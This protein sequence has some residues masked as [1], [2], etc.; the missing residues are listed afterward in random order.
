MIIQWLHDYRNWL[1][2]LPYQGI[3]FF[4]LL[5]LVGLSISLTQLF[6]RI[7][8]RCSFKAIM[9]RLLLDCLIIGVLNCCSTLT[10]LLMH[11]LVFSGDANLIEFIK[12]SPLVILPGFFFVLSAA[13]YIGNT[14]VVIIAFD[15]L[16]NKIVLVQYLYNTS[17]ID[18]LKVSLPSFILVT[19]VIW[20]LFADGWET[21]YK[22]LSDAHESTTK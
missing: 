16:L 11:E 21:N 20:L 15:Y 18:A 17:Y 14:I 9:L 8:N 7:A 22:L 1:L 19:G 12:L 6:A 2:S 4:L 3:N 10:T 13:P 5:F